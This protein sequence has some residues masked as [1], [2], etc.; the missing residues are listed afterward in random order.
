MHNDCLLYK[1]LWTMVLIETSMG[2]STITCTGRYFKVLL[3]QFLNAFPKQI[4]Q[5]IRFN[6]CCSK[7][8]TGIFQSENRFTAIK[9][10]MCVASSG[11][12]EEFCVADKHFS[13]S[14]M[15]FWTDPKLTK[16]EFIFQ[17]RQTQGLFSE[18][19]HHEWSHPYITIFRVRSI[20]KLKIK[21]RVYLKVITIVP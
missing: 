21:P 18:K 16:P 6:C 2:G 11:V 13:K 9:T 8:A 1:L 5:S 20:D 7:K 10:N 4:E 15:L 17:N 3:L 19:P 14:S 12:V